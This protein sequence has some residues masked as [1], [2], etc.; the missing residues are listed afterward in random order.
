MCTYV[1]SGKD[2]E[3]RWMVGDGFRHF[4][5]LQTGLNSSN[6]DCM[7]IGTH[8][9]HPPLFFLPS[10]VLPSPSLPSTHLPSAPF[11]PL[12]LFVCSC[13]CLINCFFPSFFNPSVL[14]TSLFLLFFSSFN[15]HT[16]CYSQFL[17]LS[18]FLLNSHLIT[19]LFFIRFIGGIELYG[20]L[21]EEEDYDT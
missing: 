20:T 3:R 4:L 15:C 6:N 5:I 13:V 9:P 10:F 19:F 14:R 18:Y 21:I 1:R 7:F 8:P 16:C 17:T 12:S 11:F 2:G